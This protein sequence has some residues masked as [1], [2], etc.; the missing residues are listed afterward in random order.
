MPN[1]QNRGR[2]KLAARVL[3]RDYG[4][5]TYVIGSK[6]AAS[7]YYYDDPNNNRRVV[8]HLDAGLAQWCG[9]EPLDAHPYPNP[10]VAADTHHKYVP[11]QIAVARALRGVDEKLR[12]ICG[13]EK[14]Y[15]DR[16]W[17]LVATKYTAREL[18]EG[19]ADQWPSAPQRLHFNHR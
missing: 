10:G 6:W 15:C 16:R 17:Q 12:A 4:E 1:H 14:Q 19:S 3:R 7:T 8:I 13:D 11:R 2:N 5:T 9:V 18:R